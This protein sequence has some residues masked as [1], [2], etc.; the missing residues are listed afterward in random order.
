MRSASLA[1][2][3]TLVII[4]IALFNAQRDRQN[5]EQL[6]QQNQAVMVATMTVQSARG[7]SQQATQIAEGSIAQAT[8]EAQ[9]AQGQATLGAYR[10]ALDATVTTGQVSA[11]ATNTAL[12]RR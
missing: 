4:G 11:S 12:T 6:Q 10:A 9:A 1:L 7:A 3:V 8:M 5:T 2:L